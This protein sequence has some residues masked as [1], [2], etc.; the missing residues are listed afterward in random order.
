MHLDFGIGVE[1][2]RSTEFQFDDLFEDPIYAVATK[3]FRFRRRSSVDLAELCAYLVLLNSKSAALRVM[4]DR[5]LAV[6][7]LQIDIKFVVANKHTLIALASAG[8]G[9]GILPKIALPTPLG[10][11][12]RPR[13]SQP[14][15]DPH[16]VNR[17][18]ERAVATPTTASR[19]KR[20]FPLGRH[21]SRYIEGW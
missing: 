12:L 6:R 15:A 13:P 20:S 9:V 21:T 8:M 10:K 1:I 18:V 3:A 4:L 11:S 17:D 16:P 14:V 5:A 2:D 7:D 19:Q